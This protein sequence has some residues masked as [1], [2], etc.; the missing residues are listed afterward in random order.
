MLLYR[1][2]LGSLYR[3]FGLRFRCGW[4]SGLGWLGLVGF[5][6]CWVSVWI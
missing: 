3:D 1:V 2:Y 5:G 4:F 6:L